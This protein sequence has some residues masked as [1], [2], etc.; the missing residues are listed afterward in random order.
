MR[1]PSRE[2]SLFAQLRERLSVP[3]DLEIE[4]KAAQGGLPNSLWSTV[5]AFANTNGGWIILGIDEGPPFEIRGLLNPDAM[6]QDFHNLLRNPQKISSAVCGATDVSIEQF[7]GMD[8]IVI[9]VPAAPRRNQPV[10]I[11]GNP[12][13]GTFV[14]VHAGDYHCTQPEVVRMIREASGESSDETILVHYTVDD[15]DRDSVSNYRRRFQTRF[16]ESPW[17]AYDDV[18]FLTAIQAYRKDRETD[19]EGI[20]VAGLLLLGT[21][22]A[23]RAWRKRHLIDYRLLSNDMD[24]DA[25]WDD[26]VPW[27]GNLLGAFETIY[28]R[29]TADLPVPFRLHGGTRVDQSPVHVALREALVNLLAHADYTERLPSVVLRFPEGYS[30]RNPGRSRVP[31]ADLISGD[32]SDPRNPDLVRMLRFIGLAEE[33]GSGMAKIIR[34]WREM[35]FQLPAIDVGTERYEFSLELRHV[36]FLREGDRAWLLSLGD[37]WSEPEQLALVCARHTGSIDNVTLR[38]LTGLHPADATQVLRGLRDRNLLQMTGGGRAT[39]YELSP[40]AVSALI[41]VTE[42]PAE[43][44][45]LP[46]APSVTAGNSRDTGLDSGVKDESSGVNGASSG[47]N[48]ADSMNVHEQLERIARPMRERQR[49]DRTTR[50]AILVALCGLQPLSLKELIDITGRSADSLRDAV[51]SLVSAHRL[52]FVFPDQPRHPRQKYVAVREDEDKPP[53]T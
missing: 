18:R 34:A 38:S 2:S 3:E 1:S 10:Y 7:D 27:E 25:R 46:L 22:S 48:D 26:R 32:R 16:P 33:A 37:D 28:P 17:N 50:D 44:L 47:V 52:V 11:K 21:D 43:Q 31:V 39:R 6:L 5:S 53:S 36:H 20:T 14:R 51:Q 8:V 41:S 19:E 23:L 13:E 42:V 24:L 12:Y 30:F 15:L 49:L 9:R 29:L 45:G 40:A 35:G 4:F